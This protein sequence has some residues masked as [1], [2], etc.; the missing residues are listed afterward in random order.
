M[1]VVCVEVSGICVG[2]LQNLLHCV[3]F[4]YVIIFPT[5]I[6]SPHE[7]YDVGDESCDG[8]GVVFLWHDVCRDVF[9]PCGA[10]MCGTA[11]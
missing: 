5:L 8:G 7:L 1:P 2:F 6:N 11:C 3:E 4:G 10:D 9:R